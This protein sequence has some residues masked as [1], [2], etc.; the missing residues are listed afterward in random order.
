[1]TRYPARI[2]HATKR[3]SKTL[4]LHLVDGHNVV[5]RCASA[6]DDVERAVQAI[7]ALVARLE[8]L[9]SGRIKR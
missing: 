6:E 5:F 7:N 8:D 2:L 3:G 4:E 9:S 1:M